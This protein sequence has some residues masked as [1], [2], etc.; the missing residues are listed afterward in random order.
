MRSHRAVLQ[1]PTKRFFPMSRLGPGRMTPS[2]N[3]I[4]AA[5]AIVWALPWS[6]FGGLI[7]LLGLLTGGGFQR[8]GRVLEFWG[9]AVV[10]FLDT[11]PQIKRASAITFGHTV[12]GRDR[13]C[14]DVTRT[15]ERVH[16]RQYE[17]WG[18]FFVPVYLLSSLVQLIRGGDAYRDNCF[19]REAF[20]KAD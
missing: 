4:K 7:G 13:H 11:F 5:L 20:S 6:F 3:Q 16:V 1:I 14:L 18:P 19:E 9:G 12:L 8:R 2:M 17:R 15:H 10:W